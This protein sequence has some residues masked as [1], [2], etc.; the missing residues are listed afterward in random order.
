MTLTEALKLNKY[1]RRPG[2]VD[3]EDEL[4][5]CML[6]EDRYN[7]CNILWKDGSTFGLQIS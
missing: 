6:A 5:W 4:Q 1:F 3:P 2:W 7:E